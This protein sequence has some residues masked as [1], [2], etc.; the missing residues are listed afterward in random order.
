MSGTGSIEVAAGGVGLLAGA[1]A[2]AAVAVVG[3]AVVML[4]KTVGT[5][6]KG[7]Q[8]VVDQGRLIR[9]NSVLGSYS[10]SLSGLTDDGAEA[11]A[12][13]AAQSQAEL[14]MTA[15][16][17]QREFER[18]PDLAAYIGKCTQARAKMTSS[19]L[20][21]QLDLKKKHSD[22]IAAELRR[23][24]TQMAA[25]R[26]KTL[27]GIRALS[28]DQAQQKARENA[29]AR[30]MLDRAAAMVSNLAADAKSQ[31]AQ[32]AVAVLRETLQ[33]AE[34]QLAGG[35]GQAAIAT[36]FSVM[37]NATVT[38]ERILS[39]DETA[40][41]L[42][43]Q[44]TETAKS[45]Q[46]QMEQLRSIDYSF[47]E[48]NNGEPLELHI[49]DFTGFF[50]GA[51]EKIEQRIAAITE[52]LA[53]AQ[54]EAFTEEE[55][56][57]LHDETEALTAQFMQE[58][59]LAYS[60]LYSNLMRN[61]LAQTIVDSYA[62]MGFVEQPDEESDCDPLE[63]TELVLTHPET[64]QTVRISLCPDLT[65]EGSMQTLISVEDHSEDLDDPAL[66]QRRAEQRSKAAKAIA[67][68]P[69][70]ASSGMTAV[71]KCKPGTGSRNSF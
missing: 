44:C 22:A 29:E 18:E 34:A 2:I 58:L 60:R 65:D 8:K 17:L 4:G 45:L 51:W 14:E 67:Q 62:E 26:D 25:D 31:S 53:S 6:A 33:K 71:Q 23:V 59:V 50:C 39:E 41:I 64:G 19:V 20:G 42:H 28:A 69:L 55:L 47:K 54:P 56:R 61:E 3:G 7:V 37:E 21:A 46:E 35:M 16:I 63:R 27:E 36:A 32:D 49:E 10:A 24:R 52:R 70:G 48:T 1:A 38:L 13:A 30:T 66:E 9:M 11:V 40:M 5:A 12:Q 15:Q 68:S 57:A 43:S